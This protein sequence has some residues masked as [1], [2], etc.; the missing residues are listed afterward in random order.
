MPPPPMDC[1]L[2][3]HSALRA[4]GA[5]PPCTPTGAG[6]HP[7]PPLPV[8]RELGGGAGPPT[9]SR[10]SWQAAGQPVFVGGAG[11]GP[12]RLLEKIGTD[13]CGSRHMV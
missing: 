13:C 11:R 8:P 10:C 2:M 6:R 9:G 1:F 12:A 7:L 4:C 3:D 5:P